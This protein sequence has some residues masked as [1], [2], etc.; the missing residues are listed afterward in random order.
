MRTDDLRGMY[1]PELT[2]CVI[3]NGEPAY[4]A[5]QIYQ[6]LHKRMVRDLDGMSNLPLSFRERLKT[7][8]GLTSLGIRKRRISKIDGTRKYLFELEDKNLIESVLLPYRFGNTACIS[9]QVGC[10]QGCAF[11]ASTI[12]GVVRNLTAAE[13]LDQVYAISLDSGERVD[14]V[15]VMGSGE[16]FENTDELVRF[17]RLA[18]DEDGMNMS[19]RNITVSTCGIADEIVRFIGEGLHINLALSLHAPTDELRQK[20]MPV[21]RRYSL[22]EV[23]AAT[24]LYFARTGRQVTYEYALI[25]GVNDG[26]KEMRALVKLLSG[27]GAHVNLIPVN[28]VVERHLRPPEEQMIA[29]IKNSLE[30]N[31][32]NVTIRREMGTDIDGA[33]GQLRRSYLEEDA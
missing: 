22:D 23:M 33:C 10:A 24:D 30:K 9:S 28:P 13:M 7:G 29:K 1:L 21:A 15:V 14:R 31:G 6:W 2:E 25:E 19:I 4:R 26:E 5:K 11:C 8:Y 27:R 3:L 17:I 20:L 18:T 32:I 12:G 16:P